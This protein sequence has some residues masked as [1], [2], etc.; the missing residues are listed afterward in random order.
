[1][2]CVGFNILKSELHYYVL[3]GSRS[4]PSHIDL[5]VHRF[6]AKQLRPNLANFF[7]QTFQEIIDRSQ[8]TKLAYRLSLD[9][10]KADQ[11]A[12]L[13][14]PYGILNLIAHER[15]LPI[16][17]FTM[18]SFTKRALGFTGDKFDAC[19]A[20]I[21]GFPA[22]AKRDTKTAALAAWMAL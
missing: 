3:G 6:D 19:D 10:K 18:Q 4:S 20:M 12:Y 14:F 21:F 1:M 13:A 22:D 5:G 17:E 15:R 16:N 8:A 7:K 11:F 2:P 9:A